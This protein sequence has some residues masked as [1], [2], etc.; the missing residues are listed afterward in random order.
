VASRGCDGKALTKENLGRTVPQGDHL[1]RIG[2]DRDPHHTGQSEVGQLDHVGLDVDEEVL[3][4][5]VSV[6]DASLVAVGNSLGNL[7][8]ECG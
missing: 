3:R 4:L 1:V 6:E 7:N 5:Q 2:S 8:G